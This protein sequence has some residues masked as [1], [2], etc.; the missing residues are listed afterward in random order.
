MST[1]DQSQPPEG[2]FAA[3]STLEIQL[4][5]T[6]HATISRIDFEVIKDGEASGPK[7]TR[8]MCIGIAA[9]AG[10]ALSGFIESVDWHATVK[11]SEIAPFIWAAIQA[12][13][14]VS[15]TSLALFFWRQGRSSHGKSAYMT[16]I[17]RLD[18]HFSVANH[19]TNQDAVTK[20]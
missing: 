11:A 10:F 2:A 8:D 9:T 6:R 4:P 3:E 15:F 16:L 13:I 14:L 18:R 19:S 17:R 1:R 7:G 12:V 20:D 5:D